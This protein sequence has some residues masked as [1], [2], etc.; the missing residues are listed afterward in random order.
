M[1]RKILAYV[2]LFLGAALLVTS[3]QNCSKTD[4]KQEG[5]SSQSSSNIQIDNEDNNIQVQ[6]GCAE[7]AQD[8][9]RVIDVSQLEPNSQISVQGKT[10]IYSTTGRMNIDQV[11]IEASNGRT[12][13]CEVTVD[14]LILKSGRLDLIRS[15]VL[16]ALELNG[17]VKQD[18]ESSIH[19]D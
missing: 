9:E 17:T 3:Y 5:S 12:L 15:H 7:L 8:F 6:S 11:T 2:F 10:F 18:S 16:H 1:K 4:F 19:V 13:L 14:K